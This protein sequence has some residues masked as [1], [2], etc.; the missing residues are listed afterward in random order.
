MTEYITDKMTMHLETGDRSGAGAQVGGGANCA[1]PR[2]C[3]CARGIFDRF[4]QCRVCGTIKPLA[5]CRQVTGLRSGT[6]GASC[7]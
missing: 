3:V 1:P 2:P 4:F 5:M 7:R 6:D